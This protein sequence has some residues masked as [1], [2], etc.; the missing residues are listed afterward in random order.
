MNQDQIQNQIQK[1]YNLFLNEPLHS[2]NLPEWFYK[3]FT[4]IFMYMNQAQV[5][6]RHET[7]RAIIGKI[8]NNQVDQLSIF[9]VELMAMIWMSTA[10]I[11]IEK[12]IL[13]FLTKRSFCESLVAKI[14]QIK[15]TKKSALQREAHVKNKF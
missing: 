2:A 1:I 14:Y 11:N 6:Y 15:E 5:P 9:E 4:D 7:I 12:D 8:S 3:K 13:K 10:P